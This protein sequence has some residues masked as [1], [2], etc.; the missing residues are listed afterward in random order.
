MSRKIIENIKNH[1]NSDYRAH[2][3]GVVCNIFSANQINGMASTLSVAPVDFGLPQNS[4]KNQKTYNVVAVGSAGVYG[5][6]TSLISAYY[7]YVITDNISK[8]EGKT[9]VLIPKSFLLSNPGA[10]W[11]TSNNII[12]DNSIDQLTA[13]KEDNVVNRKFT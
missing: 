12:D 9:A 5:Y 10:D 1:A 13:R 6:P 11:A 4:A 8:L 7:A 2:V 3:I